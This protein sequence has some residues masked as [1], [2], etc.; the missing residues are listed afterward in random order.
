M[1]GGAL[2]ERYKDALRRGHVASLRGRLEEA[3]E[4][5]SE[6]AAI[7]PERATPHTSAGDRPHAPQAAGRRA[8]VLRGGARARAARRAG[9]AAAGPQPLAALDRRLEA[10]ER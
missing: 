10:A 9:A 2:Y 8:G 5:Y 4:A 1:S 6:A 7:A 3:I